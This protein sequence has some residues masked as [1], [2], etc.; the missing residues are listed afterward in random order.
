MNSRGL[1]VFFIYALILAITSVL[2][3]LFTNVYPN[4]SYSV[5]TVK[6]FTILEFIILSIF[7]YFL[8]DRTILKTIIKII[9]VGFLVFY[10]LYYF[11]VSVFK[12]DNFPSIISFLILISLIVYFFYEKMQTVVLYPLYQIPSFWIAVGLFIYF[13]G[14]FFV[15]VFVFSNSDP[16]YIVQSRVIYGIITFTKNIIL[17]LALFGTEPDNADNNPDTLDL[18]SNL[19]LDEFSLTNLKNKQ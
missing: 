18:P 16:A 1:K 5:I 9:L 17:A 10:F 8:L 13:A 4:A 19:N 3:L 7:F 2:L 6:V 12:F 11:N 14:N 15:I